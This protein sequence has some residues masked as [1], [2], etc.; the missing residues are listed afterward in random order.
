LKLRE[1]LILVHGFPL[2]SGHNHVLSLLSQAHL[3]PFAVD[4]RR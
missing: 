3:L 4:A 2:P 1:R